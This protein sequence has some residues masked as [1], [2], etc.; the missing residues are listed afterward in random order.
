[1][2]SLDCEI[3]KIILFEKNFD[4]KLENVDFLLVIININYDDSNKN[5]TEVA[6]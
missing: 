2:L 6:R 3:N 5:L 4:Q 1:M